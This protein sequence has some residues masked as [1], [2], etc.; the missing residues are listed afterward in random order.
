MAAGAVAVVDRSIHSFYCSCS[1]S[2][3]RA[4]VIAPGHKSAGLWCAVDS[5]RRPAP[6]CHVLKPQHALQVDVTDAK[7]DGRPVRVV[8]FLPASMEST[9]LGETMPDA[10]TSSIR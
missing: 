9:A 4:R 10:Q 2:W 1:H 7:G 5:D 8:S 3:P 6:R